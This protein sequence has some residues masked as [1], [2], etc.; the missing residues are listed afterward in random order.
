[1]LIERFVPLLGSLRAYQRRWLRDDIIAGLSSAAVIVPKSMA[2]ATIAGLP[3][4]VGLYTALIPMIAYALFGSSRVLSVSTTSAIA[5]LT[6]AEIAAVAP[7]G[8][9][10]A[11]IAVAASLAFLVGAI[12]LGAAIL[13]LGFI[14]NFVSDPVLAGFKAGLGLVII[15]GQLPKLLGVHIDTDGFFQSL[16]AIVRHLPQMQLSVAAVGLATLILILVI[17]RIAP[18]APAPLIAVILGIAASAA[19]GLGRSGVPLIGA[20]PSGLPPVAIP[21]LS[22]L[23]VLFPGALG[24]ALMSFTESTAAARA[25]ARSGADRP[26]PNQDLLAFGLGNALGSLT[27]ILP[28]GG[29]TS[30]TAVNVQAGAR[31][32]LAEVVTFGTVVATLL[33]L[34]PVIGLMPAAT[35]A[36]VVVATTL[37]LLN[38]KEFRSMLKIRTTEFWWAIAALVGVVVLGTLNGILVAIV[39]SVLTLI[40]FANHPPLYVLGRK[41]GTDV[42]RPIDAEHPEDETFPGLLILRTEGGM[43]FGSAPRLRDRFADLIQTGAPRV[44]V[45]DL[46][47]VPIIEYTAL[48]MLTELD[49]NLKAR[50]IELWLSA[51]TPGVLETIHRAPLG[52]TLG[53]ERLFF[54]TQV[55]VEAYQAKAIHDR[56]EV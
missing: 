55:A 9:A 28:A 47:A 54:N 43:T 22:H 35:L 33:F 8:D 51:L 38:P 32:Q 52:D 45:F 25:F 7:T 1:M 16:V 18:R 44:V 39:L 17:G 42:F 30:Q 15:V 41:P 49:R 36:A 27:S 6:S 5:I 4:Q 12:L 11:K 21:S 23:G 56:A 46:S 50:D 37:G 53:R 34:A 24:I 2:Y 31:T 20:F 26:N 29:G 19:F 13:R 14:S 40:Y 48:K 3:V 10:E